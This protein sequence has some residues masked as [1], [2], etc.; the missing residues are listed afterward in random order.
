MLL[1]AFLAEAMGS[2]NLFEFLQYL[3]TFLRYKQ[4]HFHFFNS[5]QPQCGR[6]SV[7]NLLLGFKS[8]V[9]WSIL[10]INGLCFFPLKDKTKGSLVGLN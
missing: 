7:K 3:K 10:K 1:T 8:D 9:E 4:K 6:F 5:A 2:S